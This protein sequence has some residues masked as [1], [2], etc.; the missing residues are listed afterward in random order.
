MGIILFTGWSHKNCSQLSVITFCW[1]RKWENY[2]QEVSSVKDH[3][4]KDADATK[5]ICDVIA[6]AWGKKF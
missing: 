5:V 4:A 1:T 6:G 3:G 2:D